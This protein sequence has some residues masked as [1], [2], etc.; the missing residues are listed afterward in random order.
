VFIVQTVIEYLCTL[1]NLLQNQIIITLCQTK[2][3]DIEADRTLLHSP[4]IT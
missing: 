1:Q 4:L 2:T 3:S